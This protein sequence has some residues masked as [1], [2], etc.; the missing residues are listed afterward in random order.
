MS[1]KRSQR[2]RKPKRQKSSQME[3]AANKIISLLRREM[4]SA[5][6]FILGSLFLCL[7]ASYGF[8]FRLSRTHLPTSSESSLPVGPAIIFLVSWSMGTSCWQLFLCAY[9][10]WDDME[11]RKPHF[12]FSRQKSKLLQRFRIAST[13]INSEI[14]FRSFLKSPGNCNEA[15]RHRTFN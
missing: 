14:H 9:L 8:L 2:S 13:I 10:L 11:N 3:V 12:Y 4:I 7:T 6:P 1:R 15:R 5:A